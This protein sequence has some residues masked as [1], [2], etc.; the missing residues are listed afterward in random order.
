MKNA[1]LLFALLFGFSA[2]STIKNSTAM[3]PGQT[4]HQFHLE[5]KQVLAA[6]YL[7]FLPDGYDAGA[8]KR[9]PLIL[10]LHGAGERGTNIWLVAKHGPPKVDTAQT[11][12]PFIVVSPQ[13]PDGQMWSEDLLLALLDEIETNYAVD[14]H[15]VY[16]T[17][18]SM[19]GFGTWN[20]GLNHPEKFAAIAPICGGG[21]TILLTLAR[22][23][24]HAR[25]APLKSL[26]VWAFHGG[27]DPT[28]APDES[29]HMINT[30]KKIGCADVKLTIYPEAQ[31]DSWTQTY[32][33]QELFAWFLQH[34]R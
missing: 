14:T 33:N 2:C 18:L 29:E 12:F 31:H 9:W 17:G 30:L 24:D 21:E 28:V 34:A 10:F 8:A 25:L 4:A 15:R 27:K 3:N 5:R 1:S 7:L 16:L 26:G 11:N 19:G 32:A 23:F 13:C 22:D 20:L 6:D